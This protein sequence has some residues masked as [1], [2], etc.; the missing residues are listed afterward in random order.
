MSSSKE[1]LKDFL[2]KLKPV[3]FIV[4]ALI[5][6]G[7][8][9][10]LLGKA[11][12]LLFHIQSIFWVILAMIVLF[13]FSRLSIL[14]KVGIGFM[15]FIM[16]FTMLTFG[17]WITLLMVWSTTA[18]CYWVAMRPT[19]IDFMI[20]K[21]ASTS[22]TQGVYLSLWTFTMIPLF[23]FVEVS[24]VQSHL[25]FVYAI[26]ITIYVVYMA[27]CLPLLA[28]EPIPAVITKCILMI[29]FQMFLMMLIGQRF[30]NYMLPFMK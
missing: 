20:M 30:L 4:P 8:I 22:L 21:G 11:I 27:I 18:I 5:V 16:F 14:V 23:K 6:V 24:Y 28:Q 19:P 29:P 10:F 17:P 15:N 12:S 13:L 1:A 26:S 25:L 3:H 7:L 2:F 9:I